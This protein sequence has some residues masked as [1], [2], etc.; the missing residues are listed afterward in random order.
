MI[1][2]I[3]EMKFLFKIVLFDVRVETHD[4][5]AIFADPG[6]GNMFFMQDGRDHR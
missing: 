1:E 3:N 2:L 6:P 5:Q 4:S